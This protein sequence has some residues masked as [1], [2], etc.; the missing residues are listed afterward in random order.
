MS[1]PF[2]LESE[3]RNSLLYLPKIEKPKEPAKK[4]KYDQP[5]VVKRQK[6]ERESNTYSFCEKKDRL[7]SVY[8]PNHKSGESIKAGVQDSQVGE[9]FC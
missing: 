9:D 6:V 1:I 7:S 3:V 5:P 2:P 4:I 8:N